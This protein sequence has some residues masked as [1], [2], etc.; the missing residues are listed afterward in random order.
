PQRRDG[1]G[2]ADDCIPDPFTRFQL[3]VSGQNTVLGG[4]SAAVPSRA[5]LV[6]RVNQGLTSQSDRPAG[7]INPMLYHSPRVLHDIVHGNNDIDGTLHK[8]QAGSGW[9][10]CTGLGTPDGT[11]LMRALGG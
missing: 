1:T 11:L 4:T 3:G 9:D 7:F 5:G 10:A 2:A 8:Y 6:A